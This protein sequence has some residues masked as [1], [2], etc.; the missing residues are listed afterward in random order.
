MHGNQSQ[1][2]KTDYS[3][4]ISKKKS[5]LIFF[6]KYENLAY[7]LRKSKS[8]LKKKFKKLEDSIQIDFSIPLGITFSK[9][10]IKTKAT[11]KVPLE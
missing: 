5:L 6:S 9:I 7:F 4:T 11:P 2:Q 10:R 1:N 3:W 8:Y